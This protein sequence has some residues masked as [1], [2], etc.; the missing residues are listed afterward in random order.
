MAAP[1]CRA[2]FHK[3]LIPNKC[4]SQLR[5]HH[6]ST[7]THTHGRPAGRSARAPR[8]VAEQP[9]CTGRPDLV[10]TLMRSG[11]VCPWLA[12]ATCWS[13]AICLR[14]CSG[15]TCVVMNTGDGGFSSCATRIQPASSLLRAPPGLGGEARSSS[16]G[17][18]AASIRRFR[19]LIDQCRAPFACKGKMSGFR[20]LMI[21]SR[22]R[23]SW[24]AV[25][26]SIEGYLS[27]R[28]SSRNNRSI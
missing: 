27:V 1:K 20:A 8:Q 7:H 23:S 21:L 4:A 13:S 14:E 11:L 9:G 6:P 16:R 24:S 28:H 15:E 19:R 26:S 22:T 10:S 2:Q 12:P 17:K 18:V 3:L 25:S 5:P